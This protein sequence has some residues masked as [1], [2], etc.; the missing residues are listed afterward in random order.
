MYMNPVIFAVI[1]LT[2]FFKKLYSTLISFQT[3]GQKGTIYINKA[4]DTNNK[5]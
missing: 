5:L 2:L 1:C 3:R 4:K